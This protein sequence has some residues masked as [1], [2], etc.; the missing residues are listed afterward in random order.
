MIWKQLLLNSSLDFVF[1]RVLRDSTPGFVG[2]S[3]RPSNTTFFGF[4]G[5]WPHSSCPND[6]VTSNTAP[7]HPHATRVVVYPALF[8][9]FAEAN[10][11]AYWI[12][13]SWP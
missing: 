11:M 13:P 4:C 9:V 10:T 5:L 12:L 6:E 7:A 2:P 1:S 8:V 3:I